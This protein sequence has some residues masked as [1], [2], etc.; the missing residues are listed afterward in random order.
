MNLKFCKLIYL[1][2][3]PQVEAKKAVPRDDQNILNRNNSSIHGSPSPAR[4]KK[5][6]VGGLASTVTESD[7]KKYFDQFGTIKDVVV[8]YDHNTQRPR[9][10]G[11][12]TYDTEDAVDR[13]LYR[14][15]HE[16]NGKMVEV[17]RA[18]PKELS[19]GPNRGQLGG[20]SYGVGRVSSFLNGFSQGYNS[21]S[22]GGYGR[23]SPVTVGRNGYSLFN[24]G[25]GTGLNFEPGL[26]PS[27]GVNSNLSSNLNYGR[28][29]SPSYGVNSIK[30]GSTSGYG[31]GNGG[32][33]SILSLTSRNLWGNGNLNYATNSTN[34]NSFIGSGSGNSG[35][36]SLGSIGALWGSS[37][38]SGQGGGAGSA[39]SGSLTYGSGDVNFGSAGLGY[40]RNSGTSVTPVS[41]YAANGGY[42][43]AHADIFEGG[44]FYG[45]ST[46]RSSPS[47]L[48]GSLSFGYGLG[49]AASDV[50]GK[51][52]AGYVGGYGVANRQSTR[53]T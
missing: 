17:K 36:G 43:G 29:L 22:A 24:P 7:F 14:T 40:G 5:I 4:T 34:S 9:G 20:Y 30:Y 49:N 3:Y 44:S 12:I 27:Y 25:Y 38:S 2:C 46:W 6:F 31:G 28:G 45:D 18:V 32:H 35:M 41:S 10:F 21:S 47:E 33:N 1:D 39:L 23:F 8:M 51:N 26:N 50:M 11:F 52:S 42:D 15:F 48:E 13:V 53:G 19:P 16:L 37:F